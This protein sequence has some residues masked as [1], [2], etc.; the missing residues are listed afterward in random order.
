MGIGERIKYIRNL[1][2]MTQKYLGL[3]IGF[4]DRAADIRIAQYETGNR[5][6]KADIT[7]QIA[8]VLGVSPQALDVPNIDTEDGI[9]HTLFALEDL[10]DLKID[11][12]DGEIS[13]KLGKGKGTKSAELFSRLLS[14]ADVAEKYKKGEISLDEYDNWRYNYPA[15]DNS[16][17]KV[18]IPSAGLMD[19]I[20]EGLK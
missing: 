8:S 11:S 20:K 10:Y 2:G 4:P 14:W 15:N 7:S 1:R 18:S 16:Q 6:P 9:M 3:L 13:L 12:T 19:W 17:R 5:S